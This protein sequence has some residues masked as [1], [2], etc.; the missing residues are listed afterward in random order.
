[1]RI[2]QLH[3]RYRVTAGEDSVVD[4]EAAA[5]ERAGHDVHQFVVENPS[6]RIAAVKA[7][8]RSL[9][10]STMSARVAQTVAEFRPHVVHV[11][12]TWFA[13]S[14]QAA[15][16]P[17]A[18][19]VPVVVTVHN[20]RLGC[21]GSDL[22]RDDRICT[23]CVG[24]SP[25]AGVRH[26]CYRGS[27]VQSALLAAEISVTR[28]R[29]LLDR[30][31]RFVAPSAFMADRLVDIGVPAD[32]LVITPHFVADPG[33]RPIAPSATDEIVY[34]GRLAPGKGIDTLMQA[35]STRRPSASRLTVIGDGPLADQVRRTPGVEFIGWRSHDDVTRRLLGARALV[36]PSEWYEPFGMVLIEAMSC[37]LPVIA[38]TAAGARDIVHA[39]HP[40]L[41]P[42]HDPERLAAALSALDDR[43]VDDVGAIN[44]ARFES[45]FSE[46][47]GVAR[48]ESLYRSV[49]AP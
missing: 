45:Q 42:P 43:T 35:W 26:G 40:L 8:A 37:G 47:V 31:D 20:Y 18:S 33:P 12:N 28:R 48:L 23:A 22:F 21:I 1:M 30:V 10:N 6:D 16:A 5:M 14:W 19:G 39:P 29:A 7:L 38:T 49:G 44:R 2:L 9:G 15:I 11:H 17:S 41:V 24:H 13:L 32:R 4:N 25:L 36:M 46:P 34:V 3:A 27:R